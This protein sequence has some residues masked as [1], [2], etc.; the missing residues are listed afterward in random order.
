MVPAIDERAAVVGIV[1]IGDLR[2][3]IADDGLEELAQQLRVVFVQVDV[4]EG[5]LH[6]FDAGT[7]M[8][9]AAV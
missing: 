3:E 8:T 5:S 9:G 6:R 4:H 7:T 1:G 2:A